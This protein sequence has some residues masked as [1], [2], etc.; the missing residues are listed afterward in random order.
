V[1]VQLFGQHPRL[2][3]ASCIEIEI[4]GTHEERIGVCCL[5]EGGVFEGFRSLADHTEL[6][7][8]LG[9]E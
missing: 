2:L 4:G 1:P 8:R 7:Q 6:Q 3:Q 9:Q 5:P